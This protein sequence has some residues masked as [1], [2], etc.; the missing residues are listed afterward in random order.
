M[1]QSLIKYP[2]SGKLRVMFDNLTLDFND[3]VA[4]INNY[5]TLEVR[6]RNEFLLLVR[7]HPYAVINISHLTN[8]GEAL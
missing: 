2:N 7:T 1:T 3:A 5:G 6:D 4:T 8:A